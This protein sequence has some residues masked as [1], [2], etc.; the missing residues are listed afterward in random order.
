M[1]TTRLARAHPEMPEYR[2]DL[3]KSFG[4]LAWLELL[5]KHPREARA[6]ASR[7]FELDPSQ[8]WI[9]TNLAHALLFDGQYAKALNLYIKNRAV[10]L[11]NQNNKTFAEAVLD[12]FKQFRAKGIHHADM[13]KIEKV[14][15]AAAPN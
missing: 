7:A 9:E 15:R 14:L 13:A 8:T 6:W 10:K 11:S 4:N 5:D 1:A 3:A 2:S 12:D